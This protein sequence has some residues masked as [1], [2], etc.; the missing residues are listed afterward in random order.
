MLVENSEALRVEGFLCV[1]GS[2]GMLTASIA[3]LRIS[4][5][6]RALLP[7]NK[8]FVEELNEQSQISYRFLFTAVVGVS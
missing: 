4:L 7:G 3:V 8:L 5:S 6:D 1:G 2:M